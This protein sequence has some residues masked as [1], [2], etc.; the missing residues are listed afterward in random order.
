[1]EETRTTEIVRNPVTVSVCG[2]LEGTEGERFFV[3]L[4]KQRAVAKSRVAKSSAEFDF[5]QMRYENLE[6]CIKDVKN[7]IRKSHAHV[8]QQDRATAS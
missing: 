6:K 2:H 8:A 5:H 1:M 4:R 3:L 7:G